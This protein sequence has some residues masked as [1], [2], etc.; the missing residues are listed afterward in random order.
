MKNNFMNKFDSIIKVKVEGK[1]INNYIK[2]LIKDNINILKFIPISHKEA[3]IIIKYEDYL[4]IKEYRTIYKLK[5]I[6]K[7]G[8]LKLLSFIK[9]NIYMFISL[10]IGINI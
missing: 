4:K 8:K 1:N 3:D 5:V 7:Y 10:I 9:K 2:R 6:S